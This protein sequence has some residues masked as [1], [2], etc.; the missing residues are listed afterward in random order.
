MRRGTL[1]RR[2]PFLV[3]VIAA[4]VVLVPF[5]YLIC[6][7]FKTNEDY[8][9]SLFLPSGNGFLGIAWDRLTLEHYRQIFSQY[10]FGRYIMNS[11]FLASVTSVVATLASAM[12][13]YALARFS[14]RGRK[15]LGTLVI[16]SLLI[17]PFLLIAP[18]YQM[19]FRLGLID[20]VFG[21]VLPAMAPPF[22]VFLFRQAMASGVPFEILDAARIDGCGEIRIFFTI[23][24]PLIRP[25]VGAFL[26]I[27]FLGMWNNYLS[28]QVILQSPEHFPVSVIIAQFKGMYA[29]DYGML[30]AG[31]IVSVLPIMLLFLILQRDFIAGL[32]AGAV[33][34]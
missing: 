4:I 28:P 5:A 23:V 19:L 33:K 20:T 26:L 3:L 12:G 7:S 18:A 9:S 11:L 32:T 13:G 25:T 2:V 15:V 21:V 8:F 6:A 27:V 10:S 17:P 1:Q 29:Q 22:G 30:M 24:L 31:T 16:G 34:G 14:F